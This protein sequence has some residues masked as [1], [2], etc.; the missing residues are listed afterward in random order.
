LNDFKKLE[1]KPLGQGGERAVLMPDPTALLERGRLF[2]AAGG[3][4]VRGRPHD[5]HTNA[6]MHFLVSQHYG[7]GGPCH[8]ATGYALHRDLWFP[9]SWLW[10]G[11]R[12]LETASRR[13]L[14]FG[15]ALDGEEAVA[16]CLRQ[17]ARVCSGALTVA[18][19]P[20]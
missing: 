18:H 7:R 16:F 17:A 3:K 11:G 8:L 10:D 4:K 6:A 13:S 14:Y 9:H 12:V 2:E 20:A 1:A 5:A 19:A 15:Y